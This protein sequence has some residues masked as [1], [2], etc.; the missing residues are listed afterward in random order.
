[1]KTKMSKINSSKKNFYDKILEFR[2]ESIFF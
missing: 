1:M 2:V